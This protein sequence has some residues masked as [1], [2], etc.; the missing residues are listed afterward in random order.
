MAA[1]LS[2]EDDPVK[3]PVKIEVCKSMGIKILPPNINKSERE[4]SVHGKEVLF[5]LKAIKN[6]GEAAINAI[7]EERQKK[8]SFLPI[9]IISVPVWIARQ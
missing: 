8:L 1:L 5:G 3:I 2:L 9:S 4:F 7:V 6:L